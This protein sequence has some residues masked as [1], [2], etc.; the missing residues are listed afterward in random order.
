[1]AQRRL[2]SYYPKDDYLEYIQHIPA[3]SPREMYVL[4]TERGYRG[5]EVARKSVTLFA[6]RHIRR[7][8]QIFTE[9]VRRSQLPGKTNTLLMGPTG[10]GKTFMIELLFR[11][12][13]KLPCVIVDITGFS[14]TGYVGRDPITVLTSLIYS[15]GGDQ[16]K[17]SVG[18]VALDEFDKLATTQNSAM[19]DGQGTTKDVAGYGVQKELLK[20]FSATVVDVPLE[21]NNTA[22]SPHLRMS[23]QDISF[24]ACGAFSGFKGL[25]RMSGSTPKMGFH[26][27]VAPR[28]KMHK[29]AFRLDD[30]E[31]NEIQN[32]ANYG[33]LPE[34]MARF[35]RI[36]PLDPL[37]ETTLRAILND[38]V[39]QRFVNEFKGEG[40]DLHVDEAVVDYIV[41]RALRRQTGARGLEAEFTR[42]IEDIAFHHFGTAQGDV[43]L[44][45]HGDEI[46]AELG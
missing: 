6:Y 5:Q 43:V 12:I 42:V 37:E 8:K 24:I 30:R 7:I 46:T 29:I 21:H 20:L 35:T 27:S 15:A 13:L 38:N 34:L 44:R 28:E 25:A 14:E 26:A 22:Y 19:F 9:R 40:L 45:L 1:M 33:F 10:C 18:I 3:Y 4:L 11:D 31:V 32:F 17:A 16:K 39:I 2:D 36:V 23:T 41:Q